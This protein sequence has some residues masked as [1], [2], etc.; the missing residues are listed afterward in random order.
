MVLSRLSVLLG[1]LVEVEGALEVPLAVAVV[2]VGPLAD[3]LALGLLE[4]RPGVPAP[5]GHADLAQVVSPF[6]VGGGAPEVVMEGA[7]HLLF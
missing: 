3:V 7:R 4:Q 1:G 2:D 6:G 5:S